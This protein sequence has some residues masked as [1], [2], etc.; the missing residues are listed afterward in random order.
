MTWKKP[1]AL[2]GIMS[3]AASAQIL[4]RVYEVPDDLRM[5]LH[6]LV[7]RGRT[8]KWKTEPGTK[9]Y[10]ISYFFKKN[11]HNLFF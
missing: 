11:K 9:N 3:Q 4:I 7:N 1:Y 2:L 5:Q 6:K 8:F 10:F